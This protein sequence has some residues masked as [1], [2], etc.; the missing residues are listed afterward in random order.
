MRPEWVRPANEEPLTGR[1]KM[2]HDLGCLDS[3]LTSSGAGRCPKREASRLGTGDGASSALFAQ[4]RSAQARPAGSLGWFSVGP[5][6]RRRSGP[7]G[8]ATAAE[9]GQLA[10]RALVVH[11]RQS[12]MSCRLGRL[13]DWKR[14]Q[15]RLVPISPWASLIHAHCASAL[16]TSAMPWANGQ[17]LTRGHW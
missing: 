12:R 10:A 13:S 2:R 17:R 8:R 15:A 11:G 6:R 9:V 14:Q 1:C 7:G 5:P 3:G 16:S 4:H